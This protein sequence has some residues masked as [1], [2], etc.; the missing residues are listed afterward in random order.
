[1]SMKPPAAVMAAF[2]CMVDPVPLSGG[3]A[4]SWRSGGIMLKPVDS[5]EG[6]ALASWTADLFAGL[7]PEGYRIPRPI[8]SA[9]GGWIEQDWV[10]WTFLEGVEESSPVHWAERLTALSLFHKA[11]AAVPRPGWMNALSDPWSIADRAAWGEEEPRDI[12]PSVAGL[13]SRLINLRRVVDLPSQ[14]CHGDIGA[15]NMLFAE[16]LPPAVIDMS[17]YWR[18]EPFARAAAAVDA[19]AWAGGTVADLDLAGRGIDPP[20]YTQ[21]LLRGALRRI[22]TIS[23]FARLR[24]S[25]TIDD[26]P[27]WPSI[28]DLIELRSRQSR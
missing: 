17:P 25:S 19:M 12:H 5:G 14:V 28:V 18:P 13:V 26:D 3:E 8:R 9:S 6:R 20:L 1:M 2:G 27:L 21:L 23:E 24:G 16:N 15:G 22:M 11:L 10:A 4:K 7:R